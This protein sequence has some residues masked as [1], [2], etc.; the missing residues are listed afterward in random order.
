MLLLTLDSVIVCKHKLGRVETIASQQFVRIDARPVLVAADPEQRPISGCPNYGPTIK[1]CTTTLK[2]RQG[3]SEWLRIGGRAVCLD[4]VT[5]YTDGTPPGVVEY[6]VDA[7][8]QAW[9]R[10]R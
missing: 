6:E 5:G 8:G 10:Q 4:T 3:Y 1:P 7:A 2:V 9:V